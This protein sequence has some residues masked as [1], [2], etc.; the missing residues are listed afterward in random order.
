[1]K[2]W[3]QTEIPKVVPLFSPGLRHEG[4]QVGAGPVATTE[5][6]RPYFDHPS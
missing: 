1:M 5:V 2:T 4:N 6:Q 3:R